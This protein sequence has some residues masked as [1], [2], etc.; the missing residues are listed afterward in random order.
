MEYT[1]LENLKEYLWVKDDKN[2]KKYAD[3]IKK[4]TKL[5]DK[6]L[7][8]NLWSKTYWEYLGRVE[9]DYV[10]FPSKS[11]INSVLEV[12]VWESEVWVKRFVEDIVYLNE[13]VFGD[14]FIEY[15]AGYVSLEDIKDVEEACLSVIKQILNE[16]KSLK[17]E[18]IE[19]LSN[20]Y[21]NLE[22]PFNY[23][24]VLEKYKCLSPKWI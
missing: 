1:T 12:R 4:V 23:Q 24:N 21:E 16:N 14:V 2:D 13:D 15:R 20:S 5:F 7:G 22:N 11:P 10:L 8:Y 9:W 6:N 19:D 3:L 17:S 18:K